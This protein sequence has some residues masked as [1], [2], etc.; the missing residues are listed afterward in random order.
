M[1][2]RRQGKNF[3]QHPQAAEEAAFIRDSLAFG[4]WGPAVLL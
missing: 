2:A 3:F 4:Q 1:N